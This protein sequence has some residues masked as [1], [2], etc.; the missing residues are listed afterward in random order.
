MDGQVVRS[1]HGGDLLTKGAALAKGHL[2]LVVLQADPKL[3]VA[4][5]N[6]AA[7]KSVLRLAAVAIDITCVEVAEFLQP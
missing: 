2:L 1:K 3:R 4:P 5:S 6:A 7:S